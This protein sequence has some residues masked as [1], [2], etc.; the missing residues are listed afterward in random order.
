[1]RGKNLRV[2]RIEENENETWEDTENK[3]IPFLHD[4]LEITDE[5]YIARAHRV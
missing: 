1:M 4:E 2:D 5:L 3:L